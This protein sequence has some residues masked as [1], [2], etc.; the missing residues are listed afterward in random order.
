MTSL[1]MVVAAL[2][3]VT[4][5]DGGVLTLTK[6]TINADAGDQFD[7]HVDDDL[8][9]YSEVPVSA[10]EQHIRY[11]RFSTKEDLQ[12]PNALPGGGFANDLLSD[13][14]AGRIVFTRVIPGDRTAVMLFDPATLATTE[15]D[16]TAGSFRMGVAIGGQSIAYIDMALTSDPMTPG[17]VVHHDL[18]TGVSTR[19]T[20]DLV[21][22]INPRVSPDGN[23]IVWERC[24]SSITSCDIWSARRVSGTWTT[25]AITTTPDGESSPDTDGTRIVYDSSRAGNATGSDIYWTAVGSGVEQQLQLPD[26]QY[27]PSIAGG[28]IAFES[29][30]AAPAPIVAQSDIYL[31]EIATNRLFQITNTPTFSESLNDV[32]VLSTGEIRVVWQVNDDADPRLNNVYGATFRLPSL[33]SPAPDA[34]VVNACED[35]DAD[36]S[37]DDGHDDQGDH[38]ERHHGHCGHH[39]GEH[40]HRHCPQQTANVCLQRSV[41]LEASKL[42]APLA[43][44]DASEPL[45]P[46]MTFPLPP[47]IAVTSGAAGAGWVTLDVTANGQVSH[48]RYDA[49][50]WDHRSSDGH[51]YRLTACSGLGAGWHGGT[52]VT[53]THL[54]LHLDNGDTHQRLT[55]VSVTLREACDLG[56]SHHALESSNVDGSPAQGCSAAGGTLLGLLGAMLVLFALRPRRAEIPVPASRRRA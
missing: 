20:N 29:R 48:C 17:E 10:T 56:E 27:H 8:A 18:T 1:S 14:Q 55:A 44:Q 33:S 52:L 5:T 43:Y 9:A 23:V 30:S 16:P 49:E 19:L 28:V 26:E 46:A 41:T 54:A 12:V 13:V 45:S 35:D 40:H 11:Y 2:L 15:I 21:N 42:Y 7:P 3:S 32:S 24:P 47:H 25:G 37:H 31:Y 22:D 39:H 53:A 4:P 36:D 6:V 51:H 34:G 38:D 50:R